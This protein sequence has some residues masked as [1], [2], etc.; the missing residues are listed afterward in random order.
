MVITVSSRMLV[1]R[2]SRVDVAL[3]ES[4]RNVPGKKKW[5]GTVLMVEPTPAAITYIKKVFPL[6]S[7]DDDSKRFADTLSFVQTNTVPRA[8]T[9]VIDYIHK[10]KPFDHQE[11]VFL[12]SRDKNCYALLME[13]GTGKT[14]VILD[15][16]AYLWA[17]GLIRGLLVIAYPNGVHSNWVDV[18]VPVHLPDWVNRI[19]VAW[20]G[21]DKCLE[22]LFSQKD[23]TALRI[24][25]INVEALSTKRGEEVCRRFLAAFPSMAVVD[26]STSIKTPGAKRAKAIVRLGTYA[27]YRRIMTGTAVT[28]GALDLYMQ[29]A[30]LDEEILG[31]SSFYSY[32]ARY[33]VMRPLPGKMGRGGRPIE[34]VVGYQHEDELNEKIK[35]HSYRKLKR[36]CLSLPEKIYLPPITIE[37]TDEQK[38]IYEQFVE[39]MAA[40][41]RGRL[42]TAPLAIT[43]MMRCHQVVCGFMPAGEGE[44]EMGSPLEGANPRLDR[45]LEQI[46]LVLPF[47]KPSGTF[48]TPNK[49]LVWANYRY[50]IKQI[51][52]AFQGK[53]GKGFA[54]PYSGMTPRDMRPG[55]VKEFQDPESPLKVLVGN[56]AMAYG[57]TLTQANYSY[58]YSNG[59]DLEVR[60][61]SED[62]PHR[63]GQKNNVHYQDFVAPGTIDVKIIKSL[64]SK[65]EIASAI[66]GDKILDWLR[67]DV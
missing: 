64:R 37:L 3:L 41:F 12:L 8:H 44:D 17:R 59:F 60:Q 11:E 58:Y 56:K 52:E 16:A 9:Q 5:Q 27:P 33:A 57:L 62:R 4:L 50:N 40:E 45:L 20:D 21:K 24:F 25:A 15:N 29:F 10:T 14:K 42:I 51:L 61:Q 32:R 48:L 53:Y 18:E 66:L 22:P 6:A 47:D 55:I 39:E 1:L 46:E 23:P 34:I 65:Y 43:R 13:Q 30:F 67:G 49:V 54:K 36:E 63:I 26:E 19:T 28:K 35:A 7:W 31:F 38:R 2:E